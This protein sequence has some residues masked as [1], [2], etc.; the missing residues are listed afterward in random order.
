MSN[1]DNNFPERQKSS[2]KTIDIVLLVLG[3]GFLAAGLIFTSI[4]GC[5]NKK[6]KL[7]EEQSFI[8]SLHIFPEIDFVDSVY[9]RVEHKTYDNELGTPRDVY[10]YAIDSNGRA[11]SEVVHETH[12]YENEQKYIDGNIKSNQREGLWYA[13]FPDGTVQTKANYKNGKEE[14]RYTV[15]YSN[16]N[17]RYTG[18]YKDGVKIGEWKFYNEDGTLERSENY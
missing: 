14:G 17:V 11:T 10:Y 15:F 18:V 8:D 16:G 9:A 6:Q 1:Q 4:K 2:I 5:E 13:Y 12:Y 3:L 7:A